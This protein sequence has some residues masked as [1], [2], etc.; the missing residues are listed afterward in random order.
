MNSLGKFDYIN[1][2][3]K[4]KTKVKP[5]AKQI[6]AVGTG[7]FVGE[8]LIYCKQDEE[9]Y[10]F[11]SIPKNINR[12]IPKERFDYGIQEKIIEYVKDL[13]SDVYKI[14]YK[15]HDY[16]EKNSNSQNNKLK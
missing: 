2:L 9:N 15:Q 5:K 3:L 10:Y 8:M 12:K 6:Y 14:C 4:K 1:K 11:L 7:T 13:P 16:N